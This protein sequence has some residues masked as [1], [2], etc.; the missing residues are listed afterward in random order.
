MDWDDSSVKCSLE[1]APNEDNKMTIEQEKHVLR[2]HNSKLIV[3]INNNVCR[4]L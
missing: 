1:I 4:E 3:T 2:I